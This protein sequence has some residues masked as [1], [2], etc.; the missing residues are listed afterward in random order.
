MAPQLPAILE[1]WSLDQ[2][3]WKIHLNSTYCQGIVNIG[4]F[5]IIGRLELDPEQAK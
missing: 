5:L 1:N 3:A 4:G 2:L